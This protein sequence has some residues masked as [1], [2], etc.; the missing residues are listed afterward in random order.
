MIVDFDFIIICIIVSFLTFV[1]YN[2]LT[3]LLIKVVLQLVTE[4]LSW[5]F[6]FF[7]SMLGWPTTFLLVDKYIVIDDCR[8]LIRPE[9][10]SEGLKQAYL[11]AGIS[12]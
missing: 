8:S 2:I 9:R 6:S 4:P 5:L 10:E 12:W 1:L 3:N 11:Q 7:F